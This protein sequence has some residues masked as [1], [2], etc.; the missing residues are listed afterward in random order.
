[1]WV[2]AQIFESTTEKDRG[3]HSIEDSKAKLADFVNKIVERG[4]GDGVTLRRGESRGALER[5]LQINKL[6]LDVKKV[7]CTLYDN[8]GSGGTTDGRCL[9]YGT[10]PACKLGSQVENYEETRHMDC[11]QLLSP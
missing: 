4:L 2:D 8:E 5:F 9:F 10:V 7:R 6:L 3:E 11:P 1:M